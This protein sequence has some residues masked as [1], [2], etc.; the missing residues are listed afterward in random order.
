M[1]GTRI[2]PE[3]LDIH[4]P[5]NLATRYQTR[6]N[7]MGLEHVFPASNMAILGVSILNFGRYIRSQA[8]NFR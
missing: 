5:R 6:I 3:K 1:N 4:H 7:M 8:N 2:Y